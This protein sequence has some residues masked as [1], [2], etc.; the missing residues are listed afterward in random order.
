MEVLWAQDMP[1]V[2]GVSLRLS[3]QKEKNFDRCVGNTPDLDRHRAE[4][5]L[6]QRLRK[7]A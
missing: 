6:P 3:G 7:A 1:W 2:H 5:R 4:M